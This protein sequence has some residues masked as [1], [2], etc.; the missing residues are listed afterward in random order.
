MPGIVLGLSFLLCS[1]MLNTAWRERCYDPV[2]Q[3][4]RTGAPWGKE[5]SLLTL[6]CRLTEPE[7]KPG[8]CRAPSPM[9]GALGFVHFLSARST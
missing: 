7:L 6:F 5:V 8:V 2:L 1:M 4:K 9:C 3:L